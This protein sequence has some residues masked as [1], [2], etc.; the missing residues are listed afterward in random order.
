MKQ[1][2]LILFLFSLSSAAF[3]QRI[4]KITIN[5]SGVTEMITV[6]TDD[7][8]INISPDGN[9]ISYGVEYFSENITNYSR[10]E[11]YQGR[12]DLFGSYDDKSFQGKLKYLGKTPVTY[13]ASYDL[14]NLRG[15]LK[16]IGGLMIGY[17]MQYEDEALRGKVKSIGNNQFT[18]YSAFDNEALRGKLKSAGITN[19]NYY[20]SFDDKAFKGKIKTIGSVLFSYY[21]SFDTRYAGAMKTGAQ[22]QTINGIIFF[23]RN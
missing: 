13:F 14:E 21:S 17:Y 19:L 23:V 1:I 6:A 12:V 5:G 9:V 16:S 18:Y 15:K 20:S 8:V 4:F 22:F 10:L 3:C 7:A 2:F 11:K